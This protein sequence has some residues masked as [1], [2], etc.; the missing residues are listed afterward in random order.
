MVN[1]IHQ[2]IWMISVLLSQVL[3]SV[4]EHLCHTENYSQLSSEALSQ[5]WWKIASNMKST[6]N[7]LQVLE[8]WL[9]FACT[10][11]S[12]SYQAKPTWF[13]LCKYPQIFEIL[14]LSKHN[15]LSH[16]HAHAYS[17]IYSYKFFLKKNFLTLASLDP[18]KGMLTS[19]IQI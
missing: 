4:G 3:A 1:N 11:L 7:F 14:G 15:K 5:T 13:V 18:P 8:P 6:A 16:T 17:Y 12:V 2:G 9:Q 10:Q 19:A